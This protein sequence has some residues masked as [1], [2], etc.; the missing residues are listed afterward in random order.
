[1]TCKQPAENAFVSRQ[2]DYWSQMKD[3]LIDED[4]LGKFK[5]G[6]SFREY[7][8]KFACNYDEAR[9]QM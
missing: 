4:L 5:L 7:C 1:M 9:Y 3:K 2:E 6:H 8:V